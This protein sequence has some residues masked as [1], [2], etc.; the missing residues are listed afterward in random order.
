VSRIQ[1]VRGMNDILPEESVTWEVCLQTL[2]QCLESFSFQEIILPLVE[3]T[4]LFKRSIGDVT[5]IVEK[6]M[7]TFQDLNGDFLSLRPEGTA[8]CVRAAIEH[9]LLR[10]MQKYWYF[11]P[12]FRH[13]RPQKGR[14][15][16]FYQLGVEVFGCAEPS[17]ELELLLLTANFWRALNLEVKPKLELNTIGCLQERNTYKLALI[18]FFQAHRQSLTPEELIRLERNPLR[19]LDSKSPDIQA[20]K[21]KAP[22]LIDHVSVSSRRHFE[23]ICQ[24]LENLGIDYQI[25]PYLVRGLDYYNDLVFEWVSDQLGSQGTVCAGGRYD[26]LVENLG[27]PKVPAIGFALGFERLLLLKQAQSLVSK[28]DIYFITQEAQPLSQSQLLAQNIRSDL[29]LTVE[30]SHHGSSLKS[31]FKKAD[32]SGAS[33]ALI[34]GEDELKNQTISIKFLRQEAQ[35]DKQLTLSQHEL[36]QWLPTKFGERGC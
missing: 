35:N 28:T 19:L 25:N 11:G 3:P 12:M 31:Q 6:E 13:E 30:L 20:L 24:G 1:A 10:Q 32:K 2:K 7:Y 8:G 34:L 18:D 36:L 22:K 27:G 5:D 4:N 29:G 9:G 16:Q 17:I 14:Y 15:R 23:I 21:L 33:L 26:I